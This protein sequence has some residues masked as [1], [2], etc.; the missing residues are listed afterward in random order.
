MK[1]PILIFALML[2]VT[3]AFAQTDTVVVEDDA[4]ADI[5]D[6]ISY[7]INAVLVFVSVWLGKAKVRLGK[8]T[9]LLQ[10]LSTAIEDGTVTTVEVR[11]TVRQ[12]KELV[13]KE[14]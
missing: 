14:K 10:T 8:A 11:D 9:T 6:W 7:A 3:I 4:D 1:K 13:Q 12:A 5:P 2:L